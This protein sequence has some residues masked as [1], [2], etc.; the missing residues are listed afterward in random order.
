MDIIMCNRLLTV[1][2]F[3]N[4]LKKIVNIFCTLQFLIF[5]TV[6]YKKLEHFQSM[7]I[8]SEGNVLASLNRTGTHRERRSG[9][10]LITEDLWTR[11]ERVID[12]VEMSTS[13]LFRA[14]KV[15]VWQ[16]YHMGLS[17]VY[18]WSAILLRNL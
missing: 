10:G 16:E 7:R 1:S 5:N 13:S 6:D 4:K 17:L 11:S 2:C 8:S 18:I 9:S 3:D 14:R 15:G 12:P